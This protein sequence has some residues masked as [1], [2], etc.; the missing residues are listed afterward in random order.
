[1]RPLQRLALGHEPTYSSFHFLPIWGRRVTGSGYMSKFCKRLHF[2]TLGSV[3]LREQPGLGLGNRLHL[4]LVND[5]SFKVNPAD[6]LSLLI[7]SRQR[8]D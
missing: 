8:S 3:N 6:T 1:M 5:D 2:T 7:A 4:N